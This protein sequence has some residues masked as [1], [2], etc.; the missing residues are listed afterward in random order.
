MVGAFIVG[1]FIGAWLGFIIFA[2][3]TA[4]KGDNDDVSH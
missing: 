2:L 3:C 4:N 1:L